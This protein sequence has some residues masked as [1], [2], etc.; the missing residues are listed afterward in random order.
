MA[1]GFCP[2]FPRG[3]RSS[4]SALPAWSRAHFHLRGAAEAISRSNRKPARHEEGGSG[5]GAESRMAHWPAAAVGEHDEGGKMNARFQIL[6][7]ASIALALS[8]CTRK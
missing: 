7:I 1:A 2:A 5:S 8:G 3:R 4:G 6:G